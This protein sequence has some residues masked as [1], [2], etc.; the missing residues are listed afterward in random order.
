[1]SIAEAPIKSMLNERIDR[2]KAGEARRNEI[3]RSLLGHAEEFGLNH[4]SDDIPLKG[5]VGWVELI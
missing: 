4:D 2:N 1:M 5:M 3:L